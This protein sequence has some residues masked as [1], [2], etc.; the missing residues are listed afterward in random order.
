[1]FIGD[2]S[3]FSEKNSSENAK[4][5][6][7][8]TGYT[9]WHRIIKLLMHNFTLIF[10]FSWLVKFLQAFSDASQAFCSI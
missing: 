6:V 5:E 7:S 2:A 10:R 4:N 9:A 8:M 3:K 1:V